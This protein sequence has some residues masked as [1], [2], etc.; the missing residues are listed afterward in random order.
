MNF[1]LNIIITLI[2]L[3]CFA[4]TF[5]SFEPI[6]VHFKKL[7]LLPGRIYHPIGKILTCSQCFGLWFS[8]C[9]FHQPSFETLLSASIVSVLSS[10]FKYLISRL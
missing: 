8:L 2:G 9:Y 6:Q 7:L 5:T 10:Y 1:D 4:V 3:A